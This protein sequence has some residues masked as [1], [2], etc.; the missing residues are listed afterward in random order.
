ML[1]W[2]TAEMAM[3]GPAPAVNILYKKEIEASVD[4]VAFREEKIKFYQETFS[5]PYHS[6]S[7][8]LIDM[9]I[10]PKDTRRLII[11][12]LLVLENKHNESGPW[13]KHA[14]MPT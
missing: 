12:A 11:D 3:M 13:K 2:P 10:E 9:V 8:Q 7:K 6:A 5:T 14:V 1:V 4:P